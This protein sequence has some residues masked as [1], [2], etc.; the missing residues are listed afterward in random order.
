MSERTTQ[1]GDEGCLF[2]GT[3]DDIEKHHIVPRKFGGTDDNENLIRVCSECNKKIE[4]TWNRRFY[5]KIGAR[6]DMAP[7]LMYD[8]IK[9]LRW[10][11][12]QTRSAVVGAY[13]AYD[14]LLS[15]PT[16]DE[17]LIP[18]QVSRQ[19]VID[20]KRD[21]YKELLEGDVWPGLFPLQ[22]LEDLEQYSYRVLYG[23]EEDLEG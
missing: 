23:L 9:E 4:Q 11:L 17:A 18:E 13:S 15:S 6:A 3:V 22:E 14:K 16:N 1:S 21:A 5:E 7:N 8:S 10:T 19:Q 2:C 20:I 12:M